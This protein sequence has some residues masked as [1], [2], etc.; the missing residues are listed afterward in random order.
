MYETNRKSSRETCAST[1]SPASS[2]LTPNQDAQPP[3]PHFAEYD[4]QSA[5]L[6]SIGAWSAVQPNP[7]PP[8]ASDGNSYRLGPDMRSL[9]NKYNAMRLGQHHPAHAQARTSDVDYTELDEAILRGRST[10]MPNIFAVPNPLY[11]FSTAAAAAGVSLSTSPGPI[12]PASSSTFSMLSRHGSMS[13]TNSNRTVSPL[14]LS[15]NANPVHQSASLDNHLTSTLDAVHPHAPVRRF[16]EFSAEPNSYMALAA[17]SM[18]PPFVSASG[19]SAHA[20]D[21]T[22][23][24]NTSGASHVAS[25]RPAFAPSSIPATSASS[26][27][28]A[29]INAAV[30]PKSATNGSAGTGRYGSFGYHLP[31]MREEDSPS[32]P[33]SPPTFADSVL[34][35]NMDFSAMPLP[36][37]SNP[38]ADGSN[39]SSH[40]LPNGT[41]SPLG[42]LDATLAPS[43]VTVAAEALPD[44]D[45][46]V[47]SSYLP[48]RV[49]SLKDLRRPSSDYAHMTAA[50]DQVAS[51]LFERAAGLQQSMSLNHLPGLGRRHSLSTSNLSMP[52]STSAMG[53]AQ[54]PAGGLVPDHEHGG[55]PP[56]YTGGNT[57][58]YSVY[59]PFGYPGTVPH[60]HG[61]AHTM[62]PYGAHPGQQQQ[63]HPFALGSAPIARVL[64]GASANNGPMP[65]AG[66]GMY[67]APN[68]LGA[69]AP[70]PH[71][72]CLAFQS[73]FQH[74][75]HS[76]MALGPAH[77]TEQQP[78]LPQPIPAPQPIPSQTQQ[79]YLLQ[80]QQQQQHQHQMRRA[81]HPAI[82]SMGAPAPVASSG[83]ATH[84]G[85]HPLP[86]NPA[87]TI[88]PNMPFAD[89]GKGLTFS[90]LPKG[91]R[92]F[93]VQFKGK[94]CDLYFAPRKG[95]D[96]KIIPALALSAQSIPAS[97]AQQDAASY[98]PG[99]YVLVE[100]DRG[101]D[102]GVIKEELL[103]TES[104]LSF[105]SSLPEAVCADHAVHDGR[106]GAAPADSDSAAEHAG[107]T[108]HKPE[109]QAS[110]SCS[111]SSKDVFVKRIFRVADQREV[112]DLM[113]NKV[114]DEQKA[115][116]M[117]QDK[118]LQRKLSM[119]VADA[120]F[121]FDRRKLTFY[122]TADR[123][124]DF[125]ELVRELFKHFKTRIWMCQSQLTH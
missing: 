74:T 89:M 47:G 43:G 32:A 101:V 98:E 37:S 25:G 34:M 96:S 35:R 26:L 95:V 119:H 107:F 108:A 113:N 82:S 29:Q 5:T 44:R 31:T 75:C 46:G 116:S 45:I 71:M 40:Y 85:S 12:S 49:K 91:T 77:L 61:F 62:H 9:S 3:D 102:L 28:I 30:G 21:A 88:T 50:D 6:N 86:P 69:M 41:S 18:A 104:I 78:P 19:T 13:I 92:V 52:M 64:G 24:I 84:S 4:K 16:S 73:Q 14:G 106:P 111:S 90:S 54:V 99:I 67:G 100:A 109:S 66:S 53:L 15:L 122:F 56:Y 120:E 94:R 97:T 103:T 57:S 121:Q 63:Y 80:Q 87:T 20:S 68:M 38:G 55:I 124:V 51:A 60:G 27:P 83:G 76:Q 36:V 7:N 79:H 112:A 48:L 58:E 105:S 72:N 2:P 33:L 17:Y 93:V 23:A 39:A 70:H 125:R 117:C 118:V 115:L 81:S 22:D 1:P 114:V 123:R 10:T 11:R 8:P 42:I 59:P 110:S 65:H